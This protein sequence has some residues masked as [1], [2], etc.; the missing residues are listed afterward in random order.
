MQNH[1]LPQGS[2]FDLETMTFVQLVL[3]DLAG[4]G[5]APSAARWAL[6]SFGLGP[7]ALQ[8]IGAGIL[9]VVLTEAIVWMRQDR[10][11]PPS[12]AAKQNQLE[13]AAMD[14]S[15]PDNPIKN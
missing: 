2:L 7:Y 9:A 8:Q 1:C 10:L 13:G 4:R 5:F 12:H 14:N 15:V 3:C 11:C 6:D